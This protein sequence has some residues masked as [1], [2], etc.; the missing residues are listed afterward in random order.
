MLILKLTI[1]PLFICLITLAGRKWGAGIAGLLAGFPVVAGPIVIFIAI[2]QGTDFASISALSATSAVIILMLFTITYSW[3]SL[4]FRCPLALLFSV[5]VWLIFA[6]FLA[7]ISLKPLT[8]YACAGISLFITPFILPNKK[9]ISPLETRLHDLPWRMLLGACLTIG[10]TTLASHLG[11]SWSGIL[12]VFPVISLVLA[13][14]I[15]LTQGHAQVVKM[16]RGMINGLYSFITFFF[17]LA[18]LWPHQSIIKACALAIIA[19]TAVQGAVQ[20]LIRKQFIKLIVE[21][22]PSPKIINTNN[23]V[24]KIKD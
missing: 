21:H 14:F 9:S 16:F 6:F 7:S 11:G 10:V 18:I 4:K 24:E 8:A 20:W 12:A 13:V 5:I 19:G 22:S 15:H 3:S 23:P 17:I 2:E 1:V